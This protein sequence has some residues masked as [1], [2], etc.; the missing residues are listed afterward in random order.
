MLYFLR[1]HRNV[2]P[3]KKSI[4]YS[5]TVL[6]PTVILEP[7]EGAETYV[8]GKKVTEPTVLKSGVSPCFISLTVVCFLK[9][10]N[11]RW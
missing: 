10:C 7:S 5:L 2:F 4:Y 8:N 3:Y 11:T 1:K 9:G 6:Y